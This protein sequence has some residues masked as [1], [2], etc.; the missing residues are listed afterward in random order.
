MT[1]SGSEA[2][3]VLDDKGEPAEIAR[4][5]GPQPTVDSR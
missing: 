1:E 3:V 4:R 5:K 2:R